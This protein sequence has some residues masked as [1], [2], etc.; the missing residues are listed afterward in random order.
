MKHFYQL[1][2]TVLSSSLLLSNAYAAAGDQY[3][4]ITGSFNVLRTNLAPLA[5]GDVR[6][7]MGFGGGAGYAYHFNSNVSFWT[8]VEVNT[9]NGN[10]HLSKITEASKFSTNAWEDWDKEKEL[11]FNADIKN[12]SVQQSAMYLQLPL[13]LGV[14]GSIGGLEW[15]SWYTRG[16]FKLGYSISGQSKA[17]ADSVYLGAKSDF[18]GVTLGGVPITTEDGL[19]TLLAFGNYSSFPEDASSALGLGFSSIAYLEVGVKQALASHVGLYIGIFGE[20]SLYSAISGATSERMYEYE[21][22][23]VKGDKL[24]KLT[25]TPASHTA[26]YQSKTS[27]PMS[28]GITL[29]FSFDTKRGEDSNNRMLQMRFLDF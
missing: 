2:L 19:K 6:G 7:G 8:G 12:Y 9:Y 4:E 3:H 20:Y 21:A 22:Q 18:Y 26:L 16:G 5:S 13:M 15:L 11:D 25:Y 1:I 28:F 10:S 27:F 24:Y 14:E 29:R 17:V 23:S